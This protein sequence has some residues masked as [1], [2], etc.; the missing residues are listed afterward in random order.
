MPCPSRPLAETELSWRC[1]HHLGDAGIT[2]IEQLADVPMPRLRALRGIGKTSLIEIAKFLADHRRQV[3]IA[4]DLGVT[5]Q[6]AHQRVHEVAQQVA[7]IQSMHF[8][9][10]ALRAIRRQHGFSQRQLAFVLDVGSDVI[11]RW[12]RGEVQPSGDNVLRLMMLFRI[13][14]NDISSCKDR[15][16]LETGGERT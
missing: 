11:R 5:R 16:E 8:D 6:R 15:P 3:D 10:S 14:P 4:R 2:T 7:R 13:T 12:E 9:G 1:L